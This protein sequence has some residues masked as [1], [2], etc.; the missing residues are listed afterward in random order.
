L[1]ETS[2]IQE[3]QNACVALSP[4]NKKHDY[5][6]ACALKFAGERAVKAAGVCL[7]KENDDGWGMTGRN[8]EE[9]KHE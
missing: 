4:P 8:R 3:V 7:A 5:E 2:E 9:D 6:V 1:P